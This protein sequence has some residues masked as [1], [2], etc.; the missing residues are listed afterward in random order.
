MICLTLVFLDL[1]CM[2]IPD[3]YG[4]LIVLKI[5][6]LNAVLTTVQKYFIIIIFFFKIYL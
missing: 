1:F 5:L 6:T 4:D 2:M 3:V